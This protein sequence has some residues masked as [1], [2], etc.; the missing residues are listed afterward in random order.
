MFLYF[1]NTGFGLGLV[2]LSA[3]VTVGHYFERRRAL[4]T[5]IAVCGSGVGGFVFAPI[6][7]FLINLYNWKGAMWIISGICLNCAVM[8]SLLRPFRVS[9][10]HEQNAVPETTKNQNICSAMFDFSLLR[11]KTFI[12]Y[13][14]STFICCLGKLKL[15]YLHFQCNLLDEPLDLRHSP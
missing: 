13:A 2:H 15:K 11:K 6:S 1:T 9:G 14:I 8:G 10:H 7:E 5:G 4:A 12:L 3:M